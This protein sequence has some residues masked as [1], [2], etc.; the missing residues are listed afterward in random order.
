[1]L[2][3]HVTG[4]ALSRVIA[5]MNNH[6]AA[7]DRRRSLTR[8]LACLAILATVL[9]ACSA[10]RTTAP[11]A[12][13]FSGTVNNVSFSGRPTAV[14]TEQSSGAVQLTLIG[15]RDDLQINVHAAITGPGRYEL[16]AGDASISTLVGGDAITGGYSGRAGSAGVLTISE[17]SGVGGVIRGELEFTADHR[18]GESRFGP[19]AAF[20]SGRIVA[21]VQTANQP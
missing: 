10:D 17:Y 9:T 20:R 11:L 7:T 14:V 6:L 13:M 19:V 18:A 16:A 12:E 21:R 8:R 4:F 1:M 2:A 15:Y 5:R 3:P